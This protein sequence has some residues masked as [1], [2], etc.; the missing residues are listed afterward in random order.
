MVTC[1]LLILNECVLGSTKT[2]SS[3][4]KRVFT[5]FRKIFGPVTTTRNRTRRWCCGCL[6]QNR[7]GFRSRFLVLCSRIFIGWCG[8]LRIVALNCLS[9]WP[10]LL[11]VEI[12]WE[13][14]RSVGLGWFFGR[15][16]WEGS[17]LHGWVCFLSIGCI[18]RMLLQRVGYKVR[19]LWWWS[20][21][22]TESIMW[23]WEN[24]NSSNNR[25]PDQWTS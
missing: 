23:I 24:R 2:S 22:H 13:V 20:E 5:L 10:D 9:W 21:T 7:R 14:C 3:F 17:P 25:F 16:G 1:A 18:Q 11:L 15:D 19:S 6:H 8:G 4:F 12:F